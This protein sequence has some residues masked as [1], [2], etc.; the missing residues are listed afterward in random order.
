M[1]DPWTLGLAVVTAGV[2]LWAGWLHRPT[3]L[4]FDS[5][6]WFATALA[7]LLRGR[8]E[9]DGGDADAWAAAA[10]RLIVWH[11]YAARPELLVGAADL[12][13]FDGAGPIQ[14]ALAAK[15]AALPDV[16]SRW[17]RLLDED[18]AGLDARLGD[19]LDLGADQDP[20]RIDASL[21]WDRMA[22]WGGGD[23]TVGE[24]FG[25]RLGATWVVV[26]AA[27]EGRPDVLGA[28]LREATAPS[29]AVA[30]GPEGVAAALEAAVAAPHARLVIGFDGDAVG[31]VTR[32]LVA[33]PVARD[34][35]LAV[36]AVGAKLQ[37]PELDD[38]LGAL[39]RHEVLDTE[40]RRETPYASLG[41]VDRGA[42]P[43]G[44]A[45]AP[46]GEARWPA[47]G[48]DDGLSAIAAVDLGALDVEA[49]RGR[50]VLVARALIAWVAMWTAVRG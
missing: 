22:A 17:R 48:G 32:A 18:E 28:L 43:P 15:L 36:I 3:P 9:A 4:T 39:F 8:T 23:A 26:Q 35:L 47:P 20:K 21:S 27:P 49:A 30:C 38:V 6:R 44:V 31:A 10:S 19:P 46:L 7:T 25:A 12:G 5:G 29:T 37:G 1:T 2:A 40:I 33:N 34:R 41:W 14:R 42:V 24:G 16:P 11:P 50:E 45:G 13:A